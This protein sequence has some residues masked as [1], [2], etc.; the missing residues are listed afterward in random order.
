MPR[1]STLITRKD[2]RI[3]F[4]Q[5]LEWA[6]EIDLATAWATPNEGLCSLRRQ[7]PRL[8]VRAIVGLSGN[9][10]DPDALRELADMGELLAG[11]ASGDK[12][13]GDKRLFH[14]KVYIFRGASRSRAWIGS[15]NFTCRGFGGNEEV[16]FETSDTEDV[17]CW[18][19]RLWKQCKCTPLDESAIKSYE[20]HRKENPPRQPSSSWKPPRRAPKLHSPGDGWIKLSKYDPPNGRPCPSA[21]R[22]WDGKEQKLSHWYEVLTSVVERLYKNSLLNLEDHLPL[23]PDRP[24]R[25]SIVNTKPVHSD[26]RM[27]ER[28]KKIEGDPPLFVN[29]QWESRQIP[30]HAKVVLKRCDQNPEKVYLQVAPSP[31]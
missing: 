27:F 16:L 23:T 15:A 17:E 11:P 2:I 20:D 8:K 22:F 5:N 19:D 10:T 14:P 12:R 24:Y 21:I 26:D 28:F 7:N 13:S 6:S 9:I 30:Q 4:S 3:R 1:L 18:F 31:G 25:N 29:V